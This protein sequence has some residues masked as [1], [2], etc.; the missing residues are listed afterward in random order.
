MKHMTPIR[1]EKRK[2]L[3]SAG[4]TFTERLKKASASGTKME[5]VRVEL[6]DDKK[7]LRAHAF[8]Y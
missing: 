6:S 4:L 3:K 8:Q 1:R 5:G 2:A 7:S